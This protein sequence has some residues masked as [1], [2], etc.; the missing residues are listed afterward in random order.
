MISFRG[1]IRRERAT[2]TRRMFAFA[3]LLLLVAVGAIVWSSSLVAPAAKA[4]EGEVQ[5][6]EVAKYVPLRDIKQVVIGGFH[7]CA[8]TNAG[9]LKC[10]GNNFMGQLGD[11]HS[12]NWVPFPTDPIG[13]QSGV[14]MVA[15]GENHTC[16]L[17]DAGNVFCW[18]AD[19]KGQLGD[20][21]PLADKY[22]PTAV[23]ALGTD[24]AF[25]GAGREHTCAVMTN[26]S[27]RCWG[28]DFSGQL[29]NGAPMTDSP[30]PVALPALAGGIRTVV[31][32]YTHTCA[33]TTAGAVLCWG[34]DTYGQLGDGNGASSSPSPVPVLG[35]A[36]GVIAIAAGGTHN[37]ALLSNGDFDC[38]GSDSFGQQGNS[39]PLSDSFTPQQ[40]TGLSGIV[41]GFAAGFGHVCIAAIGGSARCWGWDGNGQLGNGGADENLP[42]Y[43]SVIP[44]ESDITS[45]S[46]GY[47]HTCTSHENGEVMC[48]GSD[49]AQGLGNGPSFLSS[50][51]PGKVITPAIC[52]E[53][54]ISSNGTGAA[55]VASPLQSEGCPLHHYLPTEQVALH[56]SPTTNQRVDVWIAPIA[57]AP[58]QT[59][60]SLVMPAADTT[61]SMK[62]ATCNLLTVS[63][64][65]SGG[66]PIA[67]PSS[68]AG[69]PANRYAP[70][71]SVIVSVVPA[72][73]NR[74]KSWSGTAAT[75]AVG[76]Q[77]N[78]FS[79]P[80]G[81]HAVSVAYEPCFT[82]TLNVVGQGAPLS[83]APAASDGC[84]TGGFAAGQSISLL[85]SAAAGWRIAGWSGTLNDAS[86]GTANSA[87]MPATDKSIT[88]RYEQIVSGQPTAT[89]TSTATPTTT[90]TTVPQPGVTLTPPATD[91]T[92]YLPAISSQ[93]R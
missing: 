83:L 74:V 92:N 34:D 62:Y 43:S 16:A 50:S 19:N 9:S 12:Q 52:Y 56:A 78:S 66:N 18:G 88:V 90:P 40:L 17:M 85:A 57:G 35:L 51:L 14:K 73:S 77:V 64:T 63:H 33:L 31:G 8:I 11:N 49:Q 38:W 70:G 75:P 55:P 10:W 45:I 42:V 72:A 81:A 30:V 89:P 93:S 65:G 36:S 60:G 25:I 46:A 2:L 91:F 47:A 37:C 20:D 4:Q 58:G 53:L 5:P 69:C 7:S 6:A 32:G 39:L 26:G 71:E 21:S 27:V 76:S 22:V 61:V 59:V 68:S 80:L 3:L 48:W 41:T 44:F 13:M 86:T 28:N 15:L 29:G 79:M 23:S 24:V 1:R 54:E 87:T 67:A 84:L 82:L